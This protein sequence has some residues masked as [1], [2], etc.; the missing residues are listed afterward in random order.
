M[1]ERKRTKPEVGPQHLFLS[2]YHA[3]SSSR[4][5][6]ISLVNPVAKPTVE[7]KKEIARIQPTSRTENNLMRPAFRRK[8]ADLF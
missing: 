8:Q 1:C 2:H 3:D 5:S 7:I 6:R 4:L